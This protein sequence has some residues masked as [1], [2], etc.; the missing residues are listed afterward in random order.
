MNEFIDKYLN[1]QKI[2]QEK[3]EYKEQKKRIEALDGEY[4][5]VFQSIQKRLWIFAGGDGDAM[6]ELQSKLVDLFEEGA[7]QGKKVLEVTGEDVA[8]FVDRLLEQT[9]AKNWKTQLNEEIAE[10]LKD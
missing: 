3:Q 5:S 8:G 10:K 6:V 1:I 2:L 9:T 7:A 4:K